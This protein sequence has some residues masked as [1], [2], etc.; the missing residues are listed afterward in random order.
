M[1]FS[2]GE[3]YEG[4]F[5]NGKKHGMGTFYHSDNSKFEG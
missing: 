2:N 1:T 3:R 5:L 4:Q